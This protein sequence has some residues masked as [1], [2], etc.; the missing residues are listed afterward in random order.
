MKTFEVTGYQ[1]V[2]NPDTWEM[3]RSGELMTIKVNCAKNSN[4]MIEGEASNKMNFDW[5]E[6]VTICQ[7]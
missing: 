4:E 5:F 3:E 7:I 2:K 6:A 1:M